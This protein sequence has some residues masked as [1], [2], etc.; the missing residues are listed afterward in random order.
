MAMAGVALL[1]EGVDR[2]TWDMLGIGN[3]AV[4]LLAEGVDRNRLKSLIKASG[5]AVALLAEGVDRNSGGCSS[6]S[7]RLIV[8]LLAEGVDRNCI[9]LYMVLSRLGRPPRGGRG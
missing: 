1:A 7:S 5:F 3:Y 4:A 9:L 8:A 2:N 6:L